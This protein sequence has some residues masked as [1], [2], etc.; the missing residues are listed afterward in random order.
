MT[1]QDGLTDEQFLAAVEGFDEIHPEALLT[2]KGG[3]IRYIVDTVDD[4]GTVLERKYRLG[5]FLCAVDPELRYFRLMN[6]YARV[7]WSVQLQHP[8]RR[9]RMWYLAPPKSEEIIAFRRLLR[10]L[11]AGE[12]S[13]VRR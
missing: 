13:I 8:D 1:V 3:R 4:T 6:P 9:V 10:Q 11:E 5:G 12:I 7:S 2:V